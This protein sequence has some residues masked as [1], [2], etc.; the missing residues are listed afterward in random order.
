M[1]FAVITVKLLKW[2]LVGYTYVAI[3]TTMF[4]KKF[5]F[6]FLSKPYFK[7]DM[8]KFRVTKKYHDGHHL[9]K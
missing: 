1:H 3:T 2:L 8:N 4:L 9:R 5:F 7:I 6:I